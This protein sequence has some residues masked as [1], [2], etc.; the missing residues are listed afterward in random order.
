[1]NILFVCTGNTC[2]SPMAERY[3]DSL[4]LP[5]VKTESRGLSADGS[6]VSKNA[7]TVMAEA[8]IDINGDKSVQL[9]PA[10]L[11]KA[12]K[13]FYMSPSHFTFLRLYANEN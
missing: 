6:P 8:G 10:D 13:I 11:S 3:L 7:V 2:R 4:N 9:T 1:M 12:D 5:D